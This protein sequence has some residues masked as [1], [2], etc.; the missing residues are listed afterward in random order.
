M[1]Q[2]TD[3]DAT[4]ADLRAAARGEDGIALILSVIVMLVLTISVAGTITAVTANEHAFGRD[5]QTNRALNIA[6]AGM[7]AGVAAV[8]ALPATAT[9]LSPASGTTD[10]GSWSYSVTRAQDSTNPD[11]YLWTITSTGVSPDGNVSRIVSTKVTETVTHNSSSTTTTVPASPSY[12]Y[13][14]FLGDPNSDCVTLGGGNSFAGNGALKVDVYRPRVALPSGQ[15]SHPPARGHSGTLSLYVG[16]KY[17]Y[18]GNNP[19]VGTSAAKIK[20][21]TVV[22]GCYKNNSSVVCSSSANSHIFANAYSSTQNDMTKPTIDTAGMPTRGQDR[23]RGAM[24]IRPT[25]GMPRTMSSYPSGYTA[26][27]VQERHVRQRR[28]PEHERGTVDLLAFANFDC[29]YYGSDGTLLGRLKWTNGSPGALIVYGNVFIDGNLTAPGQEYAVYTGRGNLYVNGVVTLAGQAMICA[30]PKS[31]SPCLGN[32]DPN[33]NLLELV[34][35]NAGNA[36]NAF[37]MTGQETFEGVAFMNGNFMEAGNGTTNG[38]VIADT[39]SVSGNG[40]LSEPDHPS[41]RRP[42][43]LVHHDDHDR[44][45]GHRCLCPGCRAPGSS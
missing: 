17:K 14:F 27:S 16:K 45:A 30:S 3:A 38:A 32:Y 4:R 28:H 43:R 31:G 7:N 10:N 21:A 18:Q 39:A 26:D 23:P 44:R 29:R 19:T 8:K 9:S 34:A 22:G 6:E 12:A 1:R 42:R 33:T 37:S 5:R 41:V 24:T 13:G 20:Q 25:R 15:R 40:S 2:T 35:V 11:L 36:P